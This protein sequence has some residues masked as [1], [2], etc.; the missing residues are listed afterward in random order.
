LGQ[1]LTI[2][3][4]LQPALR[5]CLQLPHGM[6][7]SG[8]YLVVL[9]QKFTALTC[10]ASCIVAESLKHVTLVCRLKLVTVLGLIS[11][12]FAVL[13]PVTCLAIFFATS[14]W[15]ELLRNIFS[16]AL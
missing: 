1:I 12:F 9:S 3:D 5:F 10:L 16:V 14:A 8:I 4:A 11:S 15:D 2:V 13:C 7:F 6:S